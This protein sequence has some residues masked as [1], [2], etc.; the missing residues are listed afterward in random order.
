MQR[1]NSPVS[2]TH[3]QYGARVLFNDLSFTVEDGERIALAGHNGAGKDVYKRQPYFDVDIRAMILQGIKVVEQAH[4]LFA[5]VREH[6]LEVRDLNQINRFRPVL[7]HP[8][9][10]L[11]KICSLPQNGK[12]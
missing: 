8:C 1:G 10:Q 12:S 2:Y 4:G 11:L 7:L 9:Q 6:Q 5:F 3:L